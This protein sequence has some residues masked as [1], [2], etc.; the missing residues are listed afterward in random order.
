MNDTESEIEKD[1]P[2]AKGVKRVKK[3][4]TRY[5]LP[6]SGIGFDGQLKMLR[7]YVNASEGRTVPVSLDR[8][9]GLSQVSRYTASSCNRFFEASNFI[10]RERNGYRPTEGLMS[11]VKQQPWN[12]EKAKGF[13]RDIMKESWYGKELQV[14][15]GTN[16]NMATEDLIQAIGS[17]VGAK[18]EE[19]SEL[20]ILVKFITYAGLVQTD[21]N[22]GK[23]SLS[24]DVQSEEKTVSAEGE[25]GK[26]RQAKLNMP[27]AAARITVNLNLTLDITSG[28]A[29]ENAQ[30]IRA[31]LDALSKE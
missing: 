29:E 16:P 24:E 15:F 6:S 27:G 25:I 22:T 7:A 19:K 9:A 17:L 20:G 14:L 18:P 5:A 1:K 31:I 11:F 26:E 13:L 4:A 8:V 3:S 10:V 28:T 30:R 12:E 21:T 2:T 23:L